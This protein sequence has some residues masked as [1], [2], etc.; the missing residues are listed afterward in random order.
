MSDNVY[1]LELSLLEEKIG[2]VFK[3]KHLAVTAL[4]HSSYSN[5]M[6]TKNI[7]AKCNERMEFL[8]D[9]VLSIITSEYIFGKYT[10]FPEGELT[11][12]RAN[13]VCE[14][15]LFEY[16]GEIALGDYMYLGHGEERS[17]GRHHKAI[18][19]DAFEAFLAAIYLDGGMDKAREFLMPYIINKTDRLIKE[20]RRE[21]YKSHLQQFVQRSPGDILEYVLVDETGPAHDKCFYFEVRLNNNV[22]GR[23]KG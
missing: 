10:K 20:G 15:A 2:Y 18:L 13:S 21:D 6:R 14:S 1:P 17:G 5:E 16:A 8:G 11:K 4:T 22:I 12:I 3:N 23:G 19:A 9:S 7:G